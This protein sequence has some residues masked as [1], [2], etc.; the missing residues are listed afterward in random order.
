MDQSTARDPQLAIQLP[1]AGLDELMRGWSSDGQLYEALSAVAPLDMD[2]AWTRRDI[3]NRAS[4]VLLA[5]LADELANLPTDPAAWREHLPVATVVRRQISDR[6]ARPTNWTATARRFGWP[7]TSYVSHPRSR[8]QDETTLQLLVWT[9]RSLERIVQRV[10]AI[11]PVLV[12]QVEPPVLAL[13][14]LVN[15]DLSDIPAARPDRLDLRSVAASGRPWTALAAVAETIVQ[16]ETDLAL[17]AYEL[18]QPDPDLEWRLFHLAVL[19]EVLSAL[20]KLGGRVSWRA[21]LN[22][23][24]SPGPQFQVDVGQSRWDLWFEAAASATYYQAHSP[25]RRATSGVVRNQR[26]IGADVMLCLPG[27]RALTLECKWSPYSTYVGRDGYH[28]A[29]G[30]AVEVR[31]GQGIQAWSYVV[32]PEELVQTTSSER[33]D[34]P[35]SPVVIGACSVRDL[36]NLIA[37]LV[38][39]PM[40]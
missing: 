7:P 40:T 13:L 6:P 35:G 36:E 27:E 5:R 29:A 21:P 37:S 8:E 15:E 1:R 12:S 34:W 10:H 9:A 17:L 16:S 11:A 39:G 14:Q 19:G 22:S 31:S 18:I 20:R 3:E 33:L 38:S 30:Y 24:G 4:R 28:Q 32:G 23:S 25:Y 26:S 2:L